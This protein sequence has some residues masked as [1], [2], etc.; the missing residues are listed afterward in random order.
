MAL[1][2]VAYTPSLICVIASVARRAAGGPKAEPAADAGPAAPPGASLIS[3]KD[4]SAVRCAE[5]P[6]S[7]ARC[8]VPF[9]LGRLAFVRDFGSGYR[10]HRD[11]VIQADEIAGVCGV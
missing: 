7:V 3:T 11:K 6:G 1:V 8:F 4:Y 2:C 9:L 10:D 5:S